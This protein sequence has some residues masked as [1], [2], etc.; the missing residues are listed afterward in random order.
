[1]LQYALPLGVFTYSAYKLMIRRVYDEHAEVYE[2]PSTSIVMCSLNEEGFIEKA[3]RSLEEQNVRRMYPERFELIIV[4][5]ASED[6]TV[7]IAEGYA[8][9]VIQSPRGKLTARDMGI[10]Q[11]RGD[12]IV[13][14]DA[15]CAYAPNWL[16]VL[17]Q[18]FNDDYVVA[19]TGPRLVDPEEGFGW[20]IL[21]VWMTL[22]DVGP[23][24]LRITG[25]NSAFYKQAYYDVGGFDLSIPQQNVH[26]MVREEEIDF[27]R[28][29]RQLGR[30]PVA[31]DAPCFTSLRRIRFV[32]HGKR[33]Q[34]YLQQRVSGE[35]F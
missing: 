14:V 11:A 13:A 1:M 21:G 25:Q 19:V 5:S 33:Y 22:A 30:V 24:G 10:A 2:P 3:L 29:L 32:G 18:Y 16:N 26:E 35:R 34:Q 17:L 4:D 7:E 8:D 6:R 9:R 31:W 23:F 28:K 20:T 27:A 15:D 12:I